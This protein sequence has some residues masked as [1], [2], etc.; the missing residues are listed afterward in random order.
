MALA[1]LAKS[2][3]EARKKIDEG[4]VS[5]GPELVKLTDWKHPVTVPADGLIVKLGK[6]IVRVR[7]GS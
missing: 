1:G 6:A 3:G 7:V 2:N 4:A 5:T